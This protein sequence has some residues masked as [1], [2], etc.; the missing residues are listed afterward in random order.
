MRYDET[1][2][3]KVLDIMGVHLQH[4]RGEVSHARTDPN[5]PSLIITPPPHRKVCKRRARG[6]P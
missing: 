2:T 4:E 6:S 1:V 5:A 3:N